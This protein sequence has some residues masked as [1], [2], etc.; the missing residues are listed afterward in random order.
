MLDRWT[1]V[2]GC[3]DTASGGDHGGSGGQSL[4]VSL[5]AVTESNN[6]DLG[7]SCKCLGGSEGSGCNGAAPAGKP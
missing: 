4:P 3:K 6:E 2:A 1:A 7:D 5:R